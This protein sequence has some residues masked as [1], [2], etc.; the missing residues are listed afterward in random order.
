MGITRLSSFR[1]DFVPTTTFDQAL[2]I[3][4]QFVDKGVKDFDVHLVGWADDGYRGRWPRRY[5]AESELGGNDGLKALIDGARKLGVNVILEDDYM[6][7]YTFS[8]GGIIGQ[9]PGL[10]NIWPNWSYGFNSR[11]DTVRGVNKLPVFE[12]SGGIY[13]LLSLIHI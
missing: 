8:S 9:I 2:T 5:P 7:G 10:R 6:F 3:I 11:W 13:L 4:R 12:G 1:E